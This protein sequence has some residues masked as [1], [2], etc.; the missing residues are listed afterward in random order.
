MD[1]KDYIKVMCPYCLHRNEDKCNVVRGIDGI[2]RCVVYELAKEK[3]K[4]KYTEE[5]N[6][7]K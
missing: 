6:S 4:E 2:Y 1:L 3:L 7:I 5:Q